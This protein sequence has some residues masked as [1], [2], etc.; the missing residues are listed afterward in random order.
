MSKEATV[1]AS[2]LQRYMDGGATGVPGESASTGIT[3]FHADQMPK[4]KP[5]LV[6]KAHPGV[7]LTYD[8][9]L[10]AKQV[11]RDRQKQ[12]AGGSRR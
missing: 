3:E 7:Q 6:G 1:A 11:D 4:R 10:E 8:R 5:K 12:I 2:I 9:A